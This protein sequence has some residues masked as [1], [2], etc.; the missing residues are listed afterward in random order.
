VEKIAG[1]LSIGLTYTVLAVVGYDSHE[2]AT[3]TSS[4]I[5]GL[6]VVFLTGPVVFVTIGAACFFGY[7]LDHAAHAKIR[8]ALDARDAAA[9]A[10]SP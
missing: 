2:G 6:Q 7:R 5:L 9:A 3:N 4:A 1:A 8:A 10:G